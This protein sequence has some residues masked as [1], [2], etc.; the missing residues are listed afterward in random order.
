MKNRLNELL[1]IKKREGRS[2]ELPFHKI[3]GYVLLFY[4]AV[5]VMINYQ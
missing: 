5:L 1:K 2:S 3:S 4:G